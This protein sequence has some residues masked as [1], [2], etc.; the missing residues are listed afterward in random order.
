VKNVATFMLMVFILSTG[1]ARLANAQE[2]HPGIISV[3]HA[4]LKVQPEIM[5]VKCVLT[6]DGK[7][8]H[9][10]LAALA[11]KRTD[12]KEKL[13]AL[14]ATETAIDIGNVTE[15]AG[16]LSPQQ[17]QIQAILSMR[18]GAAPAPTAPSVTVSCTVKAE[19]AVP[20]GSGDDLFLAT[21][22]LR[23]KI[24]AL[25]TP[26]AAPKK[27][28]TPEE[29]EVAEETAAAA[30]A[31]GAPAADEPTF[32]FV[33]KLSN[34]EQAKLLADA[35]ANAKSHALR[36]AAAAGG[37]LGPIEIVTDG[38]TTNSAAQTIMNM[39]MQQVTGV[40]DDDLYDKNT[41]CSGDNPAAVSA[42]ADVTVTY[43][44]LTR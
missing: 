19:F 4:A 25:V 3:G 29:Q 14:G 43:G 13:V 16:T 33:H 22:D 6:A 1:A 10:A 23:G 27:D 38:D 44:L 18:H 7:D 36:L 30:G 26:D 41:E 24:K 32:I 20:S 15:G 28:L 40:S 21:S 5:R 9:E 17:Q 11:Q 2:S 31:N 35:V 39:E 12:L 34:A 8:A 42:T 37:T